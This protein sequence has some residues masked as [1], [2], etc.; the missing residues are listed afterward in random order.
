MFRTLA[1]ALEIRLDLAVEF[2]AIATRTALE[3]LL[4]NVAPELYECRQ[5]VSERYSEIGTRAHVVVG[6][7]ASAFS[8]GAVSGKAD[9]AI[10]R[11]KKTR[12]E[13]GMD[14]RLTF[15]CLHSLQALLTPG[16]R[17]LS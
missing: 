2:Q 8:R 9:H 7:I 5:V 1:D 13:L 6:V 14:G 12:G 3:G 4:H 17:F 16:W 11:G 15:C 10:L